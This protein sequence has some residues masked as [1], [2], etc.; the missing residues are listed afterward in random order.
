MKPRAHGI[1]AVAALAAFAL[2][3]CTQPDQP[4][5][6]VEGVPI[7]T[8]EVRA[9]ATAVQPFLQQGADPTSQAVRDAVLAEASTIIAQRNDVALG[10]DVVNQGIQA[11]QILQAMAESD[12]ASYAAADG[13]ARS[14]G[15]TAAENISR[16]NIV[17]EALGESVYLEQLRDLDITLNPKFGI[18]APSPPFVYESNLSY[19]A[20]ADRLRG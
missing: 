9:V 12:A 16:T 8:S 2:A 15:R 4:A 11:S 1:A 17:V 19:A 5:A 14:G 6:S 10:D 20:P 3:G 18:W 13:T 7:P